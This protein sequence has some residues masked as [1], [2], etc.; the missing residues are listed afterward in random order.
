MTQEQMRQFNDAKVDG[1][2]YSIAEICH[3]AMRLRDRMDALFI[4]ERWVDLTHD[5]RTAIVNNVKDVMN[6]THSVTDGLFLSIVNTF[7]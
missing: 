3:E 2:M 4:R 1:K 7:K 5:E 6:D